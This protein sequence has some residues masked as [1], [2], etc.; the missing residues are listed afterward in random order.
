MD[1]STARVTLRD[2]G[3][4]VSLDVHFGASGEIARVEGER[5]RDVNGTGVLTPFEGRYDRF[6]R[7]EGVM[8]P[9]SAEVAWLLPAGRFDYWRGRPVEVSYDLVPENA[10]TSLP[11]AR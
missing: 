2:A 6:V 5:Y 7:R 11:N 3:L 9:A 4:A 10:G 8:V 1:D